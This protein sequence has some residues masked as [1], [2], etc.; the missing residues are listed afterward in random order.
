M[1]KK[2]PEVQHTCGTIKR[3]PT[4]KTRK[5]TQLK[6]YKEMAVPIPLYR[7]ENWTLNR[8]DKRINETAEMKC[9]RKVADHTLRDEI[10]YLTVRNELQVF[11]IGEKIADR[12]QNW[13]EQLAR[14]DPHRAA[15]QAVT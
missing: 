1:F 3:I 4:N 6:F 8:A 13:Y 15:R 14:M 7:C 12:K 10:S 2:F 11:N 9:L 5:G